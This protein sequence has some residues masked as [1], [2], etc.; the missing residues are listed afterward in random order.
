MGGVRC[1]FVERT[2]WQKRIGVGESCSGYGVRTGPTRTLP[3]V[4]DDGALRGQQVGVVRE[5]KDGRVDA[6][7][8]AAEVTVLPAAKEAMRRDAVQ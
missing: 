5:H 1:L 3:K 7:V 8:T 6:K 4:A 2:D